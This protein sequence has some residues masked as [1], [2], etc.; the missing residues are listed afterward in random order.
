MNVSAPWN[1]I[2]VLMLVHPHRDC[3]S[4]EISRFSQW[5]NAPSMG[6]F[7]VFQWALSLNTITPREWNYLKSWP[8][9]PWIIMHID[10][11]FLIST[12]KT[13]ESS[14]AS[15]CIRMLGHVKSELSSQDLRQA[16]IFKLITDTDTWFLFRSNTYPIYLEFRKD[17][18]FTIRITIY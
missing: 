4:M 12:A 5:E 8:Q 7:R 10:K 6:K 17:Y 16:L 3:K 9:Y 18:T 11:Y 1:Y 2:A 14:L 15:R 13:Y